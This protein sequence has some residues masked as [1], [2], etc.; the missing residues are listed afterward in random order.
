MSMREIWHMLQ[1]W[2]FGKGHRTPSRKAHMREWHRRQHEAIRS[3]MESERQ[4][5]EH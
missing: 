5:G 3:A 1:H 4:A 2:L